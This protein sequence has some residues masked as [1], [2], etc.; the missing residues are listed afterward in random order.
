MATHDVFL[1]SADGM[2]EYWREIKPV[3]REYAEKLGLDIFV[4]N[5]RSN[6]VQSPKTEPNRLYIKYYSVSS[7]CSGGAKGIILER[8]YG[9][10]LSGHQTR[11]ISVFVPTNSQE[12]TVITDP[13]G[14][15]VGLIDGGTFF[16]LFDVPRGPNA[17]Q[18]TRF[19]M[20]DY[21]DFIGATPQER[22]RRAKERLH[23]LEQ[24]SPAN[25]VKIAQP[26]IKK[27]EERLRSVL[28]KTEEEVKIKEMELSNARRKN[29]A[30]KAALELASNVLKGKDQD[31][32]DL[33]SHLTALSANHKPV[34]IGS[35]IH[36]QLGQID[37]NYCGL[38]YDIGRFKLI[39][40]LTGND[41]TV[42]CINQT[43]S[44]GEHPHPHV[45]T[46]GSPCLGNIKEDVQ[47]LLLAM[48]L[49][50]LARLMKFYLQ[51]VNPG[52]WYT[53]IGNWPVKLPFGIRLKKPRRK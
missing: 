37:I 11:G 52:D 51:T 12:F 4:S 23:I 1:E 33:F 8:A 16:V 22:K 36:I 20:N 49:E 42:L 7:K 34:V 24:N 17:G 5:P 14:V 39:I 28:A 48:D 43:R 35:E 50:N 44:I 45:S 30:A 19:I 47:N 29:E 32:L 26:W 46:G 38:T 3:L 25:F 6:I 13:D 27:G 53:S 18:L 9:I 2:E 21:A 40:Q 31:L 10:N 41:G 15:Q